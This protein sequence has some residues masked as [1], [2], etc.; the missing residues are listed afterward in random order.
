[1]LGNRVHETNDVTSLMIFDSAFVTIGDRVLIG[2]NV[3]LTTD[4]HETGVESRRQGILFAR[5]ISIG[6]DCWIG[7][8]TTVLAG[9]EI[10]KGC[11]IGAGAVVNK[12][13][14]EYSLAAGIPAKVIKTLEDPDKGLERT[15]GEGA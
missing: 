7:A 5:P 9:V 2:P 11:T 12:H 15:N 1:M 10:G 6:D 8:G 4:T 13:I 3:T 14:P